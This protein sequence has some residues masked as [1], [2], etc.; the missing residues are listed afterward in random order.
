ML[1]K[2]KRKATNRK[3]RTSAKAAV[4]KPP[5]TLPKAGKSCPHC[6]HDGERHTLVTGHRVCWECGK[7][8][9]MPGGPCD[10]DFAA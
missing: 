5:D 4:K 9:T 3:G 2:I 1:G 8:N 10:P 6:G 7:D